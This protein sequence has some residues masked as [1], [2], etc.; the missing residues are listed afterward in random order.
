MTSNDPKTAQTN[1]KLNRKN[2]KFLKTGSI[3]ANFENNNQDLDEILDK[4]DI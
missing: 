4:N 1:T 3:H 2:K